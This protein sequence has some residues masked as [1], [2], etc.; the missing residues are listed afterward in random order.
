M[1]R[2]SYYKLERHRRDPD[3]TLLIPVST[4]DSVGHA[5]ELIRVSPDD[6]AYPFWFWVTRPW[7][8]TG[9]GS[10]VDDARLEELRLKHARRAA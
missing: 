7:R 3:G 5:S 9:F 1:K 6:A 8:W 10:K 2:V 4:W